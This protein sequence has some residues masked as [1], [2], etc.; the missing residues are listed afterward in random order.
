MKPLLVTADLTAGA[1]AALGGELGYEIRDRRGEQPATA[2]TDGAARGAVGWVLE[3]ERCG[4]EELSALP[5][6]GLVACVRGGPVNVDI[7][8]ATRRGIPVLYTP[9]RNAESVADF[10]IGQIIALVRHIAATHHL[11]R[12]GA[13]T[14]ERDIRVRQRKDVIWRPADPRVPIPYHLYRG[15]ELRTL[16]LGLLGLGRAGRRVAAKARALDMRVIAHDPFLVPDG[17][18]DVP[19]VGMG[20]LLASSDVLS[21]HARGDQVL[22]GPGEL[23]AMR[24]GAFLINTARAAILDY[25][26]LLEVLRDGRLGGAALDVFPDEPLT[27]DDPLL[28]LDNVLLTPHIAGA[29]LNVVDHYSLSLVAA[30]RALHGRGDMRDVSVANPETLAKWTP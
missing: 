23:R 27:P 28:A 30:L 29:S 8:A 17:A 7:G 18:S 22:I 12:S 14:E 4:D 2:L 3:S 10:V 25:A 16:T 13:L 20:E 15:P 5:A 26:A 9:G 24:S 6:L 11:L 1:L 19:L 21:L